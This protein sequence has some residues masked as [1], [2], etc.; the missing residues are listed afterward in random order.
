MADVIAERL[1]ATLELAM[2]AAVLALVIGVVL[3]VLYRYQ[4]RS[5]G[6]AAPS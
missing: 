4:K 2:T 6:S 5:G 3:G 1:P